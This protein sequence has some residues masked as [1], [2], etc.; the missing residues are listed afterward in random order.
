MGLCGSVELNQDWNR[1][2]PT[3]GL[4]NWELRI[5]HERRIRQQRFQHALDKQL[6]NTQPNTPQSSYRKLDSNSNNIY[7]TIDNIHYHM[8]LLDNNDDIQYDTLHDNTIET[9][10][11]AR[12][13]SDAISLSEQQYNNR[14]NSNSNADSVNSSTH[15]QQHDLSLYAI[16]ERH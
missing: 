5:Q 11:R 7:P 8:Q 10:V 2:E 6:S 13:N 3:V 9:T 12:T 1:A 16:E 4:S 14:L 15:N